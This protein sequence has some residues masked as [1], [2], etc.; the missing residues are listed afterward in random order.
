MCENF[1]LK[2]IEILFKKLINQTH[3][4]LA[5]LFKDDLSELRTIREIYCNK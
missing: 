1:R 4:I 5:V 2:G 3:R